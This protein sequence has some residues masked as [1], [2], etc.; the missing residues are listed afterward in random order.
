MPSKISQLQK[1]KYYVIPLTCGTEISQNHTDRKYVWDFRGLQGGENGKLLFSG[2]RISAV[3]LE[4][5][6]EDG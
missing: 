5:S 2:Y 4:K 1:D 6:Y 3:Q